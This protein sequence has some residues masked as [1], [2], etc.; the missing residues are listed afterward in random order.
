[1]TSATAWA[2]ARKASGSMSRS[3]ATSSGRLTG[4]V[5]G[6]PDDGIPRRVA[7]PSTKVPVESVES[8]KVRR[9]ACSE[10]DTSCRYRAGQG[11]PGR[12]RFCGAAGRVPP[13]SGVPTRPTGADARLGAST[14]LARHRFAARA[15]G[16]RLAAIWASIQ[17]RPCS[18][19]SPDR[20]QP[21][22]SASRSQASH[23][24]S[25][26]S[27]DCPNRMR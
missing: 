4:P 9:V 1:M 19:N 6:L 23:Q 16:L 18:Q 2:A 7:D 22:T 15:S 24:R 26:M 25:A 5:Y 13:G 20:C 3:G 27:G 10:R 14:P 21:R 8:C 12:C 11:T 17:S